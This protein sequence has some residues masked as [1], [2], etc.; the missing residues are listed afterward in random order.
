MNYTYISSTQLNIKFI[1]GRKINNKKATFKYK[2][3]S[4]NIEFVNIRR[5]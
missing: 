3:N 2:N 5:Y 4:N 1:Y